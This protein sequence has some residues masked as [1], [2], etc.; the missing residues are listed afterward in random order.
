[1]TTA[2]WNHSQ[3][4]DGPGNDPFHKNFSFEETEMTMA[5]SLVI[6]DNWLH[7]LLLSMVLRTVQMMISFSFGI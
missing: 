1:M 4:A 6:V 7:M 5:E 3:N 2:G